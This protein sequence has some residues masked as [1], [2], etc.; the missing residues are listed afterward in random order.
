MVIKK[1]I[2]C[3]SEKFENEKMVL[4]LMNK[5]EYSVK[6]IDSFEEKDNKFIVTELCNSN[7]KNLI[8]KIKMFF[9]LM[10]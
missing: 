4:I 7:L 9:V 5:C 6:Y 2:N 3:D 8:I 1:Y 10:K